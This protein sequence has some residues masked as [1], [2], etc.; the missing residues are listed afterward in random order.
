MILVR[1][2]ILATIL[3]GA[4]Y[5]SQTAHSFTPL[6]L[7]TKQTQH[8]Q[9]IVQGPSLQQQST[10]TTTTSLFSSSTNNKILWEPTLII[11]N[12]KSI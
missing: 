8:L 4:H 7:P 10:T 1:L 11:K 5:V 9:Q 2:Q 12:S 6:S 3:L